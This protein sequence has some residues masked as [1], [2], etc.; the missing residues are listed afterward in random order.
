MNQAIKV[1]VL[2]LGILLLLG[3]EESTQPSAQNMGSILGT[4][5][6]TQNETAIDQAQFAPVVKGIDIT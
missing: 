3:C 1:F 4:G 5:T 6:P 2:T